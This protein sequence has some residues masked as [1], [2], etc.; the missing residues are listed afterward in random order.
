MKH[1][2]IKLNPPRKGLLTFSLTRI[3]CILSEIS[4]LQSSCIRWK[5]SSG[6]LARLEC[7][8]TSSSRVIMDWKDGLSWE[9]NRQQSRLFCNLS[10]LIRKHHAV[11]IITFHETPPVFW[12][13]CWYVK[14]EFVH[15]NP[16]RYCH[17]VYT[18]VWRLPRKKLP[19]DNS[20]A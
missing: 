2:S 15:G 14:I 7:D 13:C 3:S 4:S 20:I 10:N 17:V 12:A 1:S 8:S 11:Y 9:S 18:L 19:E 5:L 16:I 6:M